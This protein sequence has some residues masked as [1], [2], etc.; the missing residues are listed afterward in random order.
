[1]GREEARPTL[2]AYDAEIRYQD[3]QIGR[4][5][6]A[7]R[8]RHDWDR[9]AVVLVGDHGEGLSQHGHA[10]HGGTWN[11]QLRSPLLIRAP[12]HTP[13]RRAEAISLVDTLPTLLGLLDAPALEGFLEQTSG[14]NVLAEGV[15]LDAVLSQDTGRRSK[16]GAYRLALT[17]ARWKYFQIYDGKKISEELYDLEADP[18]ELSDISKRHPET[19]RRLRAQLLA[20]LEEQRKRAEHLGGRARP[21]T[22]ATD[23]SI[24]EQ[25]L[26]LGYLWEAETTTPPEE[27]SGRAAPAQP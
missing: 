25:L 23:P 19:T 17:S 9:T 12:G 3:F 27:P 15:E 18:F 10:G 13:Q 24:L 7:L 11:E 20:R 14:R 5:L 4:L 6:D 2:N 26:T 16:A 22:R 21:Q 8:A 1:V